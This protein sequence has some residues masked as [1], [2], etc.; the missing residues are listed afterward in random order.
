M[1][2][3][4][5]GEVVLLDLDPS[6][7]HKQKKTRPCVVINVHPRL[8]LLTVFP[9]TD[10][11]GKSGK[12]FIEIPDLNSAGLTKPSVIDTYQIRTLSTQ[13]IIKKLGKISDDNIFDCRKCIALIYEIDEEHL[14]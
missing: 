5:V 2:N 14:A 13:R 12:V 7:G 8:D 1:S 11:K 6:K 4:S 9:I 10:S 3:F